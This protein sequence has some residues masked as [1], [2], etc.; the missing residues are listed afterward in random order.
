MCV[1]CNSDSHTSYCYREKVDHI[2]RCGVSAVFVT[3]PDQEPTPLQIL[4][5]PDCFSGIY[6]KIWK[7]EI[8]F[9]LI[10]AFN[11]HINYIFIKNSINHYHVRS[12]K[13]FLNLTRIFNRKVRNY[14][15]LEDYYRSTNEI[16]VSILK[17]I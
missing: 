9:V 13:C 11:L 15:R 7:C 6:L 16:F 1:T 2:Q 8:N 14:G 12:F 5:T 4:L 17:N 10:L 3:S